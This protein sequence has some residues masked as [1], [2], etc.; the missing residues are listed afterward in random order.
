MKSR[1]LKK[2]EQVYRFTPA[3]L[4]FTKVRPKR[5]NPSETTILFCQYRPELTLHLKYSPFPYIIAFNVILLQ[6]YRI[7]TG[8]GSLVDPSD[9]TNI[10]HK[11]SIAKTITTSNDSVANSIKSRIN[12]GTSLL[13]CDDIAGLEI[14]RVLGENHVRG[15]AS[16]WRARG[17]KTMQ[18]L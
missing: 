4:V 6:R 9:I 7:S 15:Q 18:Q 11:S 8:S 5:D 1:D 12:S 10:N 3:S 16:V 2:I 13:G 14:V 17:G